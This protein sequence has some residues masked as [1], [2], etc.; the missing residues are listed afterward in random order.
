MR[1]DR[2]GALLES[3]YAFEAKTP[4]VRLVF[5]SCFQQIYVQYFTRQALQDSQDSATEHFILRIRW[6]LNCRRASNQPKGCVPETEYIYI[7]FE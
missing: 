2:F 7:A 3:I 1:R 6:Q 4:Q 5:P